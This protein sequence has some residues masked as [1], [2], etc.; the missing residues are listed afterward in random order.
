MKTKTL[1]PDVTDL[2]VVNLDPGLEGSDAEGIVLAAQNFAVD[3]YETVVKPG[4]PPTE[5]EL[6]QL[7]AFIVALNRIIWN[8]DN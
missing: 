2:S 5:R 6:V 3:F 8:D 4:V 1:P 7:C